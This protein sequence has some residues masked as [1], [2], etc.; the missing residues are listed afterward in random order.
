[1]K[2][3]NIFEDLLKRGNLPDDG[4]VV[5]NCMKIKNR[6]FDDVDFSNTSI[7][8]IIKLTSDEFNEFISLINNTMFFVYLSFMSDKEMEKFYKYIDDVVKIDKK[9]ECDNF[10]LQ[11]INGMK[12]LNINDIEDEAKSRTILEIPLLI[13]YAKNI[14]HKAIDFREFI[15]KEYYNYNIQNEFKMYEGNFV[16]VIWAEMKYVPD[17]FE[18]VLDHFYDFYDENN[19]EHKKFFVHLSQR[20]GMLIST[21]NNLLIKTENRNSSLNWF[22]GKI[23]EYD[24]AGSGEISVSKTKALQSTQKLINFTTLTFIGIYDEDDDN[25]LSNL[26]EV[27]NTLFEFYPVNRESSEY[28]MV[29]MMK[30]IAIKKVNKQNANNFIAFFEELPR[31]YEILS[32]DNIYELKELI[33]LTMA[34][35]KPLDNV[36]FDNDDVKNKLI[37][38]NYKVDME[39]LYYESG[40]EDLQ[41]QTSG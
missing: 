23:I 25:Y 7:E 3:I 12:E 37:L 27:T 30:S 13:N 33:L 38:L 4:R 9:V 31:F 22:T 29:E 1:M 18:Q 20:F 11:F 17:H 5:P 36:I 8:E 10:K 39:D 21:L 24:I 41:E 2:N 32:Y 6:Q 35:Y 16:K 28:A 19:I 15:S 26:I 34:E 40:K 14:Y